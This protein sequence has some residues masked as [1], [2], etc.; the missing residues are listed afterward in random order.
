MTYLEN[1]LC[2]KKILNLSDNHKDLAIPS[3]LKYNSNILTGGCNNNNLKNVTKI[4]NN[5]LV[6]EDYFDNL[7]KNVN[8]C[9]NQNINK[10]SN[11]K[12][13]SKIKSKKTRKQI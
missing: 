7:L 1:N 12:K 2:L 13:K 8:Q 10:K 5:D 6:I 9:V 4:N 3:L 11:T